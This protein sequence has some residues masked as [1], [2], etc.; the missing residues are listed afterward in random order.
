MKKNLRKVMSAVT[1]A[2]MLMSGLTA[3]QA[4]EVEVAAEAEAT[5][6]DKVANVQG[7]FGFNQNE[8]T[9]ADDVFDLF[10]TAV[11][12]ICAKPDFAL[13]SADKDHYVNVGGKIAYAYTTNL[14]SKA[15]QNRTVLCACATGAAT[16]QAMVSGIDLKD[17]IDLKAVAKE[18]KTL[19][20]KGSDGYTAKV[21]LQYALDQEAMLVMQVGD[22]DVPSGNQF[23]V[24]E[25]VAKY[26][27]RDVVE[28]ELSEE[29]AP[30]LESRAED[31]RYEIALNNTVE[32]K[33]FAVGEQIS[34]QGYADD[35][36]DP[37]A[38]IEFSMDG[39]ETWT[40]YETAK[41]STKR[42]VCWHFDY[43]PEAEGNYQL[44]VRARTASGKVS[45]LAANVNFTVSG[46]AAT[47]A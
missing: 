24:P 20:V 23:W 9:P 16:A 21:P 40:A 46:V 11:T 22:R 31:L 37:I 28:F 45:P 32:G 12:G 36:A 2:S 25:T 6:F 14:S 34:F 38:A 15:R 30:A 19:V 35:F 7:G 3:A 4:A 39:G 10:G 33:E 5:A 13:S 29:E 26:F 43:T 42:W 47:R 41:T 8:V 1:G 44:T 17:I 18:A 27:V